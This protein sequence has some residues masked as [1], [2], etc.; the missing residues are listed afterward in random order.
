MGE[1]K[2]HENEEIDEEDSPVSERWQYG[3]L[4]I[5]DI[6]HDDKCIKIE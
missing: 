3:L 1:R 6:L 2:H 4:Q 5:S